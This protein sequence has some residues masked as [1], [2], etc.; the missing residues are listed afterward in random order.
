MMELE[1][2]NA[3]HR[4]AEATNKNLE[5]VYQR[6]EKLETELALLKKEPRKSLTQRIKEKNK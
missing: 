3:I 6:I 1:I 2:A 5:K 4:L